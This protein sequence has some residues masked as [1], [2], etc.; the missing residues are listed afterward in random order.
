MSSNSPE[1]T[2]TR[3]ARPVRYVIPSAVS[4][5][6]VGLALLLV[7]TINDSPTRMLIAAVAGIPLVFLLD[8][9]DGIL[10]R[11][12]N[13]QTLLG[14]FIDIFAD[15][16]VELIFLRFFVRAGLVPNWFLLFFYGRIALTDLCRMR[17]FKMEKVS[18]V[19]IYLPRPGHFL[20]LSRLSRSLYAALKGLFFGI[21][22]LA[23]YRGDKALSSWEFALMI[24]V[25]VFSFLRAGPILLNYLPRLRRL[26]HPKSHV[27]VRS[28]GHSFAP[29]T[30]TVASSMLALDVCVVVVTLVQF[31]LALK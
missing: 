25:L 6:R 22:L 31:A 5:L 24:S 29:W 17:A 2:S 12:L 19:G 20:V 8:A 11:R 18:A 30:T 10:A 9:V 14:S 27:W 28:D 26:L 1:N 15:R 21:V 16:L 23:M 3:T 7:L 13:S 4:V